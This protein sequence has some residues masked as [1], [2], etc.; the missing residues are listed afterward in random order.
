MSNT[1]S[2]ITTVDRIAMV[3]GGALVVLGIVFSTTLIALGFLVWTLYALF[4]VVTPPKETVDLDGETE[5]DRPTTQ[6]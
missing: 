5:L 6:V 4:E 2:E 3:L 1:P